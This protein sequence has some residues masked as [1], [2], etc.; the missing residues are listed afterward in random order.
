EIATG[1]RK[2][3]GFLKE[4]VERATG[5]SPAGTYGVKISN[6][7][8]MLY[9]GFNG[10]VVDETIRPKRHARGFGLTALAV[11]QIPAPER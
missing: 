1:K 2:V 6:D 3:L 7:G 4:G 9:V 8:S 5:Y 10:N 11:I